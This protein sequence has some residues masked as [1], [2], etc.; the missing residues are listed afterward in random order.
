MDHNYN[1]TTGVRL[2]IPK[3]ARAPSGLEP[4]ALSVQGGA[5]LRLRSAFSIAQE[6]G[7]NQEGV[8]AK[9]GLP[10]PVAQLAEHPSPKREVAGSSPAGFA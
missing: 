8:F 6:R 5:M 1:N 7:L 2:S 4:T 10:K 3:T 9:I